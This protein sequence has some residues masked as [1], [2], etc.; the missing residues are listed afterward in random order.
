MWL[1]VF[2]L[3]CA[4]GE[5][6]TGY[7]IGGGQFRSKLRDKYPLAFAFPFYKLVAKREFVEA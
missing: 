1:S 6:F 4:A 5:G 2:W 7:F 3:Y